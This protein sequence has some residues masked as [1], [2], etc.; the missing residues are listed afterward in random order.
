MQEVACQGDSLTFG[1]GLASPRTQSYPGQLLA[2]NYARR[3]ENLGVP[4]SVV[5]QMITWGAV[6]VDDR[7][8]VQFS[9]RIVVIWAGTND[10]YGGA[11]GNDVAEQL[12]IASQDRRDDGAL[13][14]V[15]SALPR[16]DGEAASF[17]AQRQVM[18][19]NLAA[20]WAARADCYFDVGGNA[21]IGIQG[22]QNNPIY[23]QSDLTHLT[24]A[25]YTVV[26]AGVLGAINAITA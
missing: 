26:L 20:N 23:Y 18:R 5:G 6:D 25:G 22:S 15:M 21:L 1:E 9:T 12:L 17:E 2:A 14:I 3:V 19:T 7:W 16:T 4:G 11:N 10:L 13:T 8:L 24:Q